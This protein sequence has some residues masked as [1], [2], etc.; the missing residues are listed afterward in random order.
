MC[1]DSFNAAG[2]PSGPEN[3]GGWNL[4]LRRGYGS[5]HDGSARR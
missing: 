5:G 1:E 4:I 2:P 3:G